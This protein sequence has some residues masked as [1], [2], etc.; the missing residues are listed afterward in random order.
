MAAA[1]AELPQRMGGDESPSGYP[2]L[3]QKAI[4]LS[5]A[6]LAWLQLEHW[7]RPVT[8]G[9][10]ESST[11]GVT[12][13]DFPDAPAQGRIVGPG[14]DDPW[15][16][17]CQ[18][19]GIIECAVAPVVL[20]G[21][22]AGTVGLISNVPGSL[23]PEDL[24]RLDVTAWAAAQAHRLGMSSELLQRE[25]HEVSRMLDAVL[26]PD[27]TFRP[28]ATL[29][30]LVRSVGKT[31][32]ATYCRLA[33]LAGQERLSLQVSAGHRPPVASRTSWAV[34]HF[35]HCARALR[36]R[37]PVV[38]RF[39][40][41]EFANQ[42]E[43]E[44]LFT[45]RTRTAIILPMSIGPSDA[46]LLI[47]EERKSRSQ[48]MVPERLATLEFVA[49][50]I[51]SIAELAHLVQQK[52]RIERR[53]HQRAVERATRRRLA[54]ELHDEVGQALSAL[55]IRVRWAKEGGHASREELE[56]LELAAR[57]A[58]NAARALASDMRHRENED[59]GLV[60][61]KR[62]AEMM[63]PSIGCALIWTDKRPAMT[64]SPATSREIS[65]VIKESI[66]NIVRHTQADTV[67]VTLESANGRLRVTI[68]DNGMGFSPSTRRAGGRSG[69]S[70]LQGNSER[71]LQLGGT[72]DVQS[73]PERGTVVLFEAPVQ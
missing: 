41:P 48:P 40:H 64:I 67:K 63:L 31:I 7:I 13:A 20:S 24:S 25:L 29:R 27:G 2:I 10:S 1:G 18:H 23:G 55:L 49:R 33:V 70:G 51:G 57:D 72:F 53:R 42:P 47:G 73:S 50:R 22:A 45:I 54:R 35:P 11:M 39:D 8:V 44:S 36:E 28:R 14:A 43:R 60:D 58:F 26:G 68:L 15:S 16:R 71:L 62:Y 3:L 56:V 6:R 32:D 34:A 21:R 38:L 61:A 12:I 37:R 69:G 9:L 59:P 52:H 17:W 30:R 4:G 66:A 5:M 19:N 65:Y 46:L